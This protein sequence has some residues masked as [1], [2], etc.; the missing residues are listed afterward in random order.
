VIGIAQLSGKVRL[1]SAAINPTTQLGQIRLSIERDKRLRAGAFGRAIIDLGQRCG[2]AV[3]LS[4]VLYGVGGTVVQTVSDNIVDTRRVNVGVI[5]GGLAEIL[6][7]VN[8]GETVIARAGAF[9]RYGDRVRP[10]PANGR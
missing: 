7:G 6:E 3:P 8:E 2:P 4:A 9:F 5:S 10:T 1:I